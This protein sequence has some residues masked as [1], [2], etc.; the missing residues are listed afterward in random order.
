[1]DD[2]QSAQNPD[3]TRHPDGSDFG[4]DNSFR[5]GDTLTDVTGVVDYAFG[6]YKIQPTGTATH[7]ELNPRP[8]SDAN[9]RGRIDV[10]TF[11]VLNFFTTIDQGP[12]VCGPTGDLD[13]RGADDQNEF[14]RQLGKLIPGILAL[15]ADIVGLEEVENGVRGADGI[16]AHDAIERIVDELN[17]AD[18]SGE[19]AWVGEPVLAN[20]D[21]Y[22]N[23]YPIRNEII[24]RSDVV[25]PTGPA[26]TIQSDAFDLVRPGST[27]PVGRPPVAQT[28]A[29]KLGH[30]GLH[31]FV[32]KRFTVVVNHFKSKGS[33]CDSIGD[34]DTGDGQGNCNKTRVLQS[35][36]LLDFVKTL[37]K[38]SHDSD[39]LI[40]GDL[41]SYG[42]EDPVT[43]ILD[44]GFV[45]V[46]DRY[47]GDDSYTYVFD[48]QLGSLDHALASRTLRWQVRGAKVY[49]INTDEPDILDYDTTFKSDNQDA[50]YEA[51]PYRVSDHDPVLVG[52]NP[53]A[54]FYFSLFWE[55]LRSRSGRFR[56]R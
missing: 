34:P 26:R 13:C 51:E 41:N 47:E 29:E 21:P 46:V 45:D 24:Y 12:D 52:I 19:W 37:K 3:Y 30:G 27:D 14:D 4:V 40:I 17:A 15:N 44:R 35:E 32:Q 53:R 6:S 36:A 23:D 25:V 42:M 9:V 5:G 28:F 11:N 50:M 20:G 48:G 18:G 8:T 7:T 38:E 1:L 49:H 54:K 33:S 43:T 2:G 31:P 16:P 56:F 22:Y 10:A 39:V 55:W